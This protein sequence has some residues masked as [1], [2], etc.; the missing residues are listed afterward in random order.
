M[1]AFICVSIH[2][3]P[4][5]WV[6]SS[7]RAPRLQK[8][9]AHRSPATS[10]LLSFPSFWQCYQ[11]KGQNPH[12]QLLSFLS[13]PSSLSLSLHQLHRLTLLQPCSTICGWAC[14][15]SASALPLLPPLSLPLS[16]SSCKRLH[17]AKHGHFLSQRGKREVCVNRKRNADEWEIWRPVASVWHT[18][19]EHKQEAAQKPGKMAALQLIFGCSVQ[20]LTGNHH[21]R[22]K[23]HFYVEPSRLLICQHRNT[24]RDRHSTTTKRCTI[25]AVLV[26]RG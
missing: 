17:P 16:L 1:L 4:G 20:R 6:N 18:K 7:S 12:T 3:S 9:D 11:K 15:Q 21:N 8:R 13:S 14:Y 10:S 19:H 2:P 25:I 24:G 22:R 5:S 23:C 26:M